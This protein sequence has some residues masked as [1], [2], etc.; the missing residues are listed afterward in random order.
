M[1]KF[2]QFSSDDH[3]MSLADVGMSRGGKY[4]QGMGMFWKGWLCLGVAPTM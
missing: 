2:E 1:N 3:Q 4:V